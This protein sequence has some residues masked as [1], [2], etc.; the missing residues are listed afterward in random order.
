MTAAGAPYTLAFLI[1]LSP[2]GLLL[3]SKGSVD[4]DIDPI[5][6]EEMENVHLERF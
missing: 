5:A 1:K 4:F 2:L 3:F 6:H